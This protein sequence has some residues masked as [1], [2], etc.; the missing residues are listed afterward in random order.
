MSHSPVTSSPD[1]DLWR[2]MFGAQGPMPFGP[3]QD[4]IAI[5]ELPDELQA[6]V[7][8]DPSKFAEGDV[9]MIDTENELR[10][11]L[12]E[13][14]GMDARG[15]PTQPGEALQDLDAQE[16]MALLIDW[17]ANGR[18]QQ[19]Q[20]QPGRD[21]GPLGGQQFAGAPQPTSFNGG[22]G[23]PHGGGGGGGPSGG[24]AAPPTS[25]ANFTPSTGG[26]QGTADVGSLQNLSADQIENA[27]TIIRVGRE[28][29]ASDRDI[30]I[31]LMTAMQESTL[32]N[33]NHGDR[34]SLGLFQQRPSQGWGSPEQVT[35]P[36]YAAGKFY[37]RLLGIGNRDQMRLTEAAQ[38]VQISA[39]PEAYAKHEGLA[40][41]IMQEYGNVA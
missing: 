5:D 16:L 35:N 17:I 23:V 13:A 31:A 36:E 30:Q 26:V 7:R 37:E 14:L 4:S 27:Q 11:L 38:A 20:Q 29:G 10:A 34:D 15:L 32:R 19:G 12:D 1:F 8:A 2:L 40:A 25:P 18:H 21:L 39:Y 33:L 22:G 24:G 6:V 28:M 41:A 3:K 9:D